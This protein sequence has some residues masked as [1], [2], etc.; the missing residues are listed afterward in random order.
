VHE[1]GRDGDTIFIVSDLIRGVSMSDWLSGATPN[2][3]ETAQLM[4]TVAEALHHAH[5][6]GVIHRDL[7]PSN[8]LLDDAGQPHIMDFGLSKREVGEITMTVD[9][10]VLGTPAYM[11]PEQAA[12]DAHWTDRRTDIYSLGV[13][14]FRMLTGELPFRGNAQMQIHQRLTE[15]PPDPRKLN[16]HLPRDMCTICLKC[17]ERAPNRRFNNAKE[18]A[19]EFRRYLKRVPIEAR[20]ISRV[21]RTL[22]WA[23]RNPALATVILSTVFLAIAGP[24]AGVVYQRQQEHLRNRFVENDNLI[25]RYRHDI[26][27]ATGKIDD[28]ASQQQSVS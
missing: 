15:D 8:I 25:S 13:I 20:P 18:L 10:N 7:K 11:S 4:A 28:L 26:Q 24:A 14:L 5:Q 9:G 22:R 1:V 2:T 6:K 12:G 16:K 27:S 17:L 19:D 3:F 21:E 23:K